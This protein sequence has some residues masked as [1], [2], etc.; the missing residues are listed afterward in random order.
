MPT[1]TPA[2]DAPLP[3]D[4]PGGVNGMWFVAIT[5]SL[6]IVVPAIVIGVLQLVPKPAPPEPLSYADRAAWPAQELRSRPLEYDMFVAA[7]TGKKYRK[8]NFPLSDSDE[9]ML[10][11]AV[12]LAQQ[13]DFFTNENYYDS[14]LEWAEHYDTQ[15]YPPYLVA[16]WLRV[17]DRADEA[18]PWR[19]LAFERA[20]GAIVQHI[21]YEDGTPAAEHS[22]PGVAIAYDRVIDGELDTTLRLIYPAPTT[23]DQGDLYLPTFQSVYRLT[24]PATP[25]GAQTASYP[26]YLTL[27]P[28][29]ATRQTPNWFSAPSRVGRLPDAVVDSE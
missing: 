24:D 14:L 28:Q 2:N 1:D 19:I 17:N 10:H 22:I 20:T 18:E 9:A 7:E 25:L 5:L 16:E 12:W 13:D 8:A 27:L 23:D 6:F 29:T 4:R 11:Q 26:R 21:Q 3:S 15:F